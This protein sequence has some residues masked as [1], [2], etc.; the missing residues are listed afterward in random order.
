M[1]HSGINHFLEN[2]E[3]AYNQFETERARKEDRQPD[4]LPHLSAH[5]LRHTCG[6]LLFEKGVSAKAIQGHLGHSDFSTTMNVYN[7]SQNDTEW[8][9]TELEKVGSIVNG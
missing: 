7:H 6:T 8:I 3:K 9:A 1:I 2:I 4:L 5:I